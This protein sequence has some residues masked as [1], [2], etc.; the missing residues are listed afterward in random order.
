MTTQTVIL[1]YQSKCVRLSEQAPV[2]DDQLYDLAFREGYR[3][4]TVARS[5][6]TT[7]QGELA[8]V[9]IANVEVIDSLSMRGDGEAATFVSAVRARPEGWAF[10]DYGGAEIVL[11]AGAARL[12]CRRD[13]WRKALYRGDLKINVQARTVAARAPRKGAQAGQGSLF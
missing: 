8:T 7:S 2:S 10:V 9:C 1:K 13:L 4:N 6:Y 3:V 5:H 11:S 12:A